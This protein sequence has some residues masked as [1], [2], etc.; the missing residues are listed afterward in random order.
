M[1]KINLGRNLAAML[2]MWTIVVMPLAAFGQTRIVAPKNKYKVQD[3]VKLGRDAARQ[4]EQQMP[5]LNDAEATRYVQAGRRTFG[6]RNSVA[7]SATGF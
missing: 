1:R 4:V 7:V 5:I 2:V 3:D 6:Q